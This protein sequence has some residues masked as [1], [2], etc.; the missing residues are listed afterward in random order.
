M[1]F[2][3]YGLLSYVAWLLACPVL[4]FHQK[5]RGGFW[6]RMGYVPCPEGVEPSSKCIWLHGASA[7]DVL[8][9]IPLCEAFKS[10]S[11]DLRLYISYMTVSG[12][13][14]AH[15]HAG[16]FESHFFIPYD[17]PFAVRKCLHRLRPDCLIV[18]VAELWP[19]LL[20][21]ASSQGACLVL[22]NARLSDS[23]MAAYRRLFKITGNLIRL[24]D[25][26]YPLSEAHRERAQSLG[27][28]A[29][30]VGGL[31]STKMMLGKAQKAEQVLA[32]LRPYLGASKPHDVFVAGSVHVGEEDAIVACFERLRQVEDSI[33]MVWAPR[34]THRSEALCTRLLAL[35]YRVRLRSK[36]G[37]SDESCDI[38][39]LD[40][41]GELSDWYALASFSFV[42]GSLIAHGGHNILEPARW[43]K[44]V[45][46]G[47][48]MGDNEASAKLLHGR[49]GIQVQN[50]AELLDVVESLAKDPAKAQALGEMAKTAIA[51]LPDIGRRNALD[52][53]TRLSW[54]DD[55]RLS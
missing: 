51:A 53:M 3:I 38:L 2:W 49:G 20:R 6:Q 48:F 11:P 28:E 31:G 22:N 45:V 30:K 55:D 54:D 7:G 47:P 14:M 17:I 50:E 10:H 39:I 41:S 15:K 35:G 43:G 4:I 23:S 21:Q 40:T 16:L 33:Q 34:Y 18:E 27:V 1:S 13:A 5:L 19:Q 32:R 24:F 37:A 36:A 12:K 46:F 44:A 9:L 25:I 42:G 29:K 8:A 26:V 52:I